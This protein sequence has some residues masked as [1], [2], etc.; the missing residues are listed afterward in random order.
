M[1]SNSYKPRYF[2]SHHELP[3]SLS[4]GDNTITTTKMTVSY[5]MVVNYSIAGQE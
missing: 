2:V 1:I 5:N 3:A 4:I